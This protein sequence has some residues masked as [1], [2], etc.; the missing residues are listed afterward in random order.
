MAP[1]ANGRD[2]VETMFST[3]PGQAPMPLAKVASSGELSRI[4]LA[5]MV[6]TQ[7]QEGLPAMIFD[8]V[9]TG[10]GGATAT[11]VGAMM[12][13]LAKGAASLLRHPHG[14]SSSVCRSPHSGQ[15]NR[16]Q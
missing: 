12:A 7:Q 3:N 6:A 2:R 8:E 14:A 1:A 9:D 15:Q 13:T 11:T 4:G 5:L 16:R 10:L